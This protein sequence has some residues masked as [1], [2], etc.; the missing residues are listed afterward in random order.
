MEAIANKIAI[1]EITEE[2]Y[3]MIKKKR[4]RDAHI[5]KQHNY[6]D[7]L[8]SLITRMKNDGFT[9]S[10]KNNSKSFRITKAEAWGDC[11]NNWINLI[12]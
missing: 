7:E 11:D 12:E 6:I 9:L 2:E 1:I 4:E 3:Q 5:A 10:F 8:N